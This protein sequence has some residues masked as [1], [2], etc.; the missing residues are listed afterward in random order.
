MMFIFIGCSAKEA[1]K[2]ST[3]LANN[4][5][6]S[7]SGNQPPQR[8]VFAS[9]YRANG[10]VMQHKDYA[11]TMPL[12]KEKDWSDM[13]GWYG[14]SDFQGI[15]MA[16]NNSDTKMGIMLGYGI[17]I[18]SSVG[19]YGEMQKA[20]ENETIKYSPQRKTPN[21]KIINMN[22][23]TEYHGREHYPCVVAQS[24]DKNRGIESKAYRCY[25]FNPSH[26]KYKSV[27][28]K[29][30]Y[31]KSPKLPVKYKSL[32]KEY[33]Y[34]DLQNRAKRMLDSLYIKEGW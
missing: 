22:V 29:L 27:I 7:L 3:I 19:K 2:N 16:V 18:S 15:G 28:I 17:N 32:A 6:V 21:G 26:T 23:H 11:F 20:I 30:I 9:P 8:F 33:T 10:Y 12:T 5:L 4:L 24:R 31:N 13:S 25:K 14:S 1:N 34:Q